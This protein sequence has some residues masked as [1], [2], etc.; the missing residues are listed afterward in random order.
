MSPNPTL[1]G[2]EDRRDLRIQRWGREL[3]L[4][5]YGLQW[6]AAEAL[7]RI[8]AENAAWNGASMPS[9]SGNI[10]RKIGSE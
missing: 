1:K 4:N 9:D 5:R 3:H 10:G 2:S 8:S 6:F 7:Q